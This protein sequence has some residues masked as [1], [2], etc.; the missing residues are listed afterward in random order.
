MVYLGCLGQFRYHFSI[1]YKITVDVNL[2]SRFFVTQAGRQCFFNASSCP[3]SFTRGLT[4]ATQQ[5]PSPY[6]ISF[7]ACRVSKNVVTSFQIL[8]VCL[9]APK[10][11]MKMMQ[12]A[13]EVL[14]L[15]MKMRCP[16]NT[17]LANMMP[18]S[19]YQFYLVPQQD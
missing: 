8:H 1:M 12:K 19:E 5:F 17:E 3:E 6:N 11:A 7:T 13:E 4:E 16:N 9:Q 2:R 14:C 15:T 10:I 18:I